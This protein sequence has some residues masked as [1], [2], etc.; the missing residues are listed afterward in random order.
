MGFWDYYPLLNPNKANKSGPSSMVPLLMPSRGFQRK[1]RLLQLRKI[2]LYLSSKPL[3][4]PVQIRLLQ[5]LPH[6]AQWQHNWM[7]PKPSLHALV[8]I[9]INTSE[10]MTLSHGNTRLKGFSNSKRKPQVFCATLV[11]GMLNARLPLEGTPLTVICEKETKLLLNHVS[12]IIRT[13]LTYHV[14][15]NDFTITQK[16]MN[17]CCHIPSSPHRKDS[18]YNDKNI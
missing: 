18:K 9:F 1:W 10:L 12:H 13:T 4:R 15:Y 5:P 14:N 7:L 8:L 6:L 16:S 17:K 3:K 2:G 11:F